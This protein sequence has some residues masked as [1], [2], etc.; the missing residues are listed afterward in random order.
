MKPDNLLIKPAPSFDESIEMLRACHERIAAQCST[1]D[2][3]VAHL[4]LHGADTQARQAARNIMRYFHVAGPRGRNCARCLPTSP[5]G[6]RRCSN[7]SRWLTVSALTAV[8]LPWKSARFFH[9]LTRASIGSNW[10]R[11][12]R[13]WRPD[14]LLRR[15]FDPLDIHDQRKSC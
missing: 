12:A 6:K 3:F 9:W 8:T 11:Q 10:W 5:K 4:P 1:I 7:R 13:P 2:K 14:V 15:T